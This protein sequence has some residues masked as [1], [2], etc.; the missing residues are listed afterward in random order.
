MRA[1]KV[2]GGL[3]ALSTGSKSSEFI[4]FDFSLFHVF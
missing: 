3:Q 2:F 4:S 1:L